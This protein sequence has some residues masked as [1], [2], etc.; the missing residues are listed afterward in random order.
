MPPSRPP[1]SPIPVRRTLV[2]SGSASAEAA[3][4]AL[5]REGRHGTSVTSIEGLA[6]R[7]AGGFLSGI[8]ADELG[9]AVA[10][11]LD[12]VPRDAL[13]DLAAVAEL[14]GTPAAL[15]AT[16]A[17]AWAAGVDLCA[18]AGETGHPRLAALALLEAEALARL[19]PSRCRP[20]DLAARALARLQ[21][22]PATL[23]AVEIRAMADLD[24]CWRPLVAALAGTVPLRWVAGPRAVPAWVRTAGIAVEAGPP[25]APE[26]DVVSCADARHEA[27]EAF[28]WARALL[29]RGVPA[30]D[31][32]LAAAAPGD[33]D[34]LVLA[35]AAE[36]DLPVHFAHGRRVLTARDGQSC[37]ALADVLLRG[38]DRDRVV[39]L[40]RGVAGNGSPL[41]GLPADWTRFAP[42]GAALDTP[43]RW[44]KALAAHAAP[45]DIAGPL[46][47]AVDFLARGVEVAGEAGEALLRGAPRLLWRRALARAPASA[48][49]RSLGGLR[50]ADEVEPATSIAWMHAAALAAAPRRHAWLLGLNGRAWPRRSRE[51]PLLPDHV[52]PSRDL[53]PRNVAEDDR[54]AF[55]HVLATT[56]G[57]VSCSFSRRDASGRRL[58]ASPLIAGRPVRPLH[59]ARVPAHALSEPDRLMACPDA[60]ALTPRAASADSCW[61]D[62]AQGELTAHD[63]LVRPDHPAVAAALARQHSANSLKRL[64]RDPLGFVWRYALGWRAPDTTLRP[65]A[66]DAR[67]FGTL[68]HEI[69]RGAVQ[70]LEDGAGLGRAGR[71]EVAAA[72]AAA[73]AAVGTAWDAEADIPPPLLWGATLARAREMAE[74]ALCHSL[75]PLA[76]QRSHVEL[77][78]PDGGGDAPWTVAGEVPI[79]GTGLTIAGRIDRLDLSADGRRARVIDYKTGAM[80]A[81]VVLAGGSELQRCLYALAVRSLLGRR[82]EVEAGLLYPLGGADGYRVLPDQTGT[83]ETLTAALAT[84][85]A[86]LRGGAAVPGPDHGGTRDDLAFAIPAAPGSRLDE[87]RAAARLHLGTAADIWDEE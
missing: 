14:P 40:T 67:A 21:H 66:L 27:I 5:A 61:R 68:V 33:Y 13:G 36:S 57:T 73:A 63:G 12:A 72:V 4:V 29:A 30:A 19:P 54:A 82:V 81:P 42:R 83:L 78:F 53:Q 46:L 55:A 8:D 79:P 52:V 70:T 31:I 64:L 76:G 17:K 34:D 45:A 24:P 56:A 71:L 32:A 15:C 47:A 41:G 44:R 65:F 10:R 80:R 23:G 48:L 2:V 51:D 84:A 26:I 74:A 50:A 77:G 39:R 59:R 1:A 20:A 22:A 75:E 85:V 25:A 9:D 43:E 58:G 86:S 6:A 28:R 35:L 62:L 60:F 49:E 16:L 38:L 69:L 7:L 37:A 11:A 3:R 87:K 18:R